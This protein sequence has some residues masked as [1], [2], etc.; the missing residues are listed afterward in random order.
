MVAEREGGDSSGDKRD[1]VQTVG[2]MI[3]ERDEFW[4]REEEGHQWLTVKAE[5]FYANYGMVESTDPGWLQLAFHMLMGIFDRVG[6]QT[7]FQKTL[8]MVCSPCQASGVRPDEAY[9][10]WMKGEGRR[11]N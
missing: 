8:G 9:T 6:L 10:W 3:Q 1:L 11:F 7:N 5:L 2:R 4:R